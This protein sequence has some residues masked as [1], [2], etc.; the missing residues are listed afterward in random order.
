MAKHDSS[1]PVSTGQ[2]AQDRADLDGSGEEQPANHHSP[3]SRFSGDLVHELQALRR[4]LREI[5]TEVVRLLHHTPSCQRENASGKAAGR[6]LVAEGREP[7]GCDVDCHPSAPTTEHVAPPRP[8]SSLQGALLESYEDDAI[9]DEPP[10]RDPSHCSVYGETGTTP[11]INLRRLRSHRAMSFTKQEMEKIIKNKNQALQQDD[12]GDGDESPRAPVKSWSVFS[13]FSSGSRLAAAPPQNSTSKGSKGN[14]GGIREQATLPL[15]SQRTPKPANVVAASQRAKDS[16]EKDAKDAMESLMCGVPGAVMPVG[17]LQMPVS[18]AESAPSKCKKV[19]VVEAV[20]SNSEDA[21]EEVAVRSASKSSR[22]SSKQSAAV[23]DG[24]VTMSVG[25]SYTAARKFH[26]EVA[27]SPDSGGDEAQKMSY[28]GRLQTRMD[29]LVQSAF[30]DYL[31]GSLVILNAIAIGMQTDYMANYLT[32]ILPNGYVIVNSLFCALFTSEL[33]CRIIAE[34][35]KFVIGPSWRWNLFDFVL[36]AL[37]LADEILIHVSSDME[38][39]FNFSFL[40]ILRILRLVRIIRIIRILR[41]I[42]ELRAIVSS[43]MGSLKSLGWTLAL[44]FLLVYVFGVYFTQL[45]LDHR[46]SLVADPGLPRREEMVQELQRFYGSL[47]RSILSLY[48]AITGGVDWD[49]LAVPLISE[50][51]VLLGGV[52]ALYI[53]FGVLALL[54][55]VTGVFVESALKSAKE[56][57][58][59]YML[60]H[61]KDIFQSADSSG[62]GVIEWDDFKRC[63]ED[64]QMQEFFKSIDVD[65]S[66]AQ[67]VFALLDVDDT[68]LIDLDEFL[69]GCLCLHGPAKAID[70]SSLRYE[71]RMLAKRIDKALGPQSRAAHRGLFAAQDVGRQEDRNSSSDSEAEGSNGQPSVD[72]S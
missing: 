20:R 54:N 67:A 2:Q 69:N 61:V 5:P 42:G 57:R 53:A 43:I 70:V 19:C 36:V 33:V 68:G 7:V 12:G 16:M 17:T 15:R 60:H 23:Q 6:A 8:P 58:D 64:A 35:R 46:L 63:S 30:F 71:M 14:K 21:H 10:R 18:A 59:N 13:A 65:P 47:S 22:K 31:S 1:L 38:S 25:H 45:V 26:E 66:Q 49:Q 34:G 41:L 3:V 48:Q 11:V 40:R 72:M 9:L 56:D 44:L 52:V 39:G 51:H 27:P 62:E 28:W 24:V 32:D 29:R 4:S 50:V 37:Q 55:V